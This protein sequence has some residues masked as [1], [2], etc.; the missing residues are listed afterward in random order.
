MAF[1]NKGFKRISTPQCRACGFDRLLAPLGLVGFKQETIVGEGKKGILIVAEPR[2]M[3][4]VRLGPK[5]AKGPKADEL[6]FR[7]MPHFD[8]LE[9]CWII[10]AIK[11][12]PVAGHPT[13]VADEPDIKAKNIGHCRAWIEQTIEDLKPKIVI[14]MGD[15]AIRTWFTATML[16]NVSEYHMAGFAIPDYNYNTWML[17]MLGFNEYYAKSREEG[18]NNVFNTEFRKA[19]AYADMPLP[20]KPDYDGQVRILT[21]YEDVVRALQSVI[22]N[23]PEWFDYDYETNALK[24]QQKGAKLVSVSWAVDDAVAYSCP[25]RGWGHFSEKQYLEIERLLSIILADNDIKK[26]AHNMHMENAWT[27][28]ALNTFIGNWG[29]DSMVGHHMIDPRKGVKALKFLAYCCY[30]FG[31]YNL[32]I[33][34]WL[35]GINEFTGL[36]RIEEGPKMDILH[37]GG[38]DSLF[39][40]KLRQDQ[41]R[42]MRFN[43]AK[44]TPVGQAFRDVYLP[45][46][47]TM[48]EMS[49][50]GFRIDLE[51]Y[52][53]LVPTLRAEQ[54]QIVKDLHATPECQRFFDKYREEFSVSSGSHMRK[55]LFEIMGFEPSKQTKGGDSAVSVDVLEELDNPICKKVCRWRKIEKVVGTFIT[56]YKGLTTAD[57]L[58]HPSYNLHT[59]RTGRSSST[60]PNWQNIPKRDKEQKKIIRSGIYPPNPEHHLAETD[61]G[62]LEIR[63]FTCHSKD[64][65][66]ID[67]LVNGGDMHR[68]EAVHVFA[69][70][71]KEY[72]HKEVRQ[73]MKMG[74][75]FALLYGSYYRACAIKMWEEIVM[76]GLCLADKTSPDGKG[77]TMRQWLANKGVM[78]ENDFIW[79][80]RDREQEFWERFHVTREYRDRIIADYNEN[81]FV[82]TKFGFTRP[83]ILTKNQIINTPTQGTGSGMLTWS[84][85]KLLEIARKEGWRTVQNGQV[86]DSLVTSPHPDEVQHVFN[87]QEYVM[88][89]LIR[90]CFDW[91]IVPLEIE[92][93][94]TPQPN[95]PWTEL[96]GM[97]KN[98]NGLWVFN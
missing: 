72:V 93:E 34:P 27:R 42:K 90:D 13:G 60:D 68:D 35:E 36:N 88:T 81:G 80:C 51:G 98:E 50:N 15:I 64:P 19:L 1:W 69:L 86:H 56:G 28:V 21:E 62:S 91:I 43:S 96:K 3:E 83:G 29:W 31:P 84:A 46:V 94:M 22:D 20:P 6:R 89:Q 18:W 9:D 85:T 82:R 25:I 23:K 78:T 12:P 73:A 24:P 14:F 7:V 11:C 97:H 61:Y 63:V 49:I 70:P 2:T 33:K 47:V 95:M 37:Y 75:N 5:Y 53:A 30:G 38:L 87:T 67:Y 10:P 52:D 76:R 17:P 48:S 8:I 74:W 79:W 40:R 44:P 26:S 39:G 65:V 77:M 16:E 71:S 58:I 45:G 55:L 59:A 54:A 41:M 92:I 66:L 4:E 57:N 32:N